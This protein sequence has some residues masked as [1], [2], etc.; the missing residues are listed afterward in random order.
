V[1]WALAA[2]VVLYALAEG[3]FSS[4]A[5]I[6][7]QE[8]RGLTEAVA[9]FALST[10][11]GALVV[12]RVLVSLVVLRLPAV[13]IWLLLPALKI[14]AFLLLPYAT[15]PARALACYALA[16]LGCSAILPLTIS[17]AA[18]R[19]HQHPSWVASVLVGAL[20]LGVGLGSF[21]IGPLRE[22]LALPS[23]FRYSALYPSLV[24]VLGLWVLRQDRAGRSATAA[25]AA[26]SP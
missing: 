12:G 16:G 19:F 13:R 2:I 10:F 6:Y 4:W 14:A 3:T 9:G 8:D 22:W 1:F 20:M 5:I 26:G 7:L 21:M 17:L 18:Q 25:P 23:L 15:T 24:L 11:W